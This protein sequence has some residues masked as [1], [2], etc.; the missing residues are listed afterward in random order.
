MNTRE[1]QLRPARPGRHGDRRVRVAGLPVVLV[2]MLVSCGG[3]GP[4]ASAPPSGP[5]LIPPPSLTN[6]SASA[7]PSPRPVSTATPTSS[8]TVARPDVTVATV[9]SGDRAQVGDLIGIGDGWVLAGSLDGA[10]ALWTSTDG[11]IWVREEISGLEERLGHLSA[12]A[13]RNDTMVAV[14]ESTQQLSGGILHRPLA[15]VGRPGEWRVTENFPRPPAVSAQLINVAWSEAG[16]VAGGLV[17]EGNPS[18]WVS[19]DAGATWEGPAALPADHP[20][21][22]VSELVYAI[23][24]FVAVG[25]AIGVT[26]GPGVWRSPNGIEWEAQEVPSG[27]SM[28]GAVDTDRGPLAVG[29]DGEN[30]TVWLL[31]A[32]AERLDAPD[33]RALN[34]VVVVDQHPVVAT[35]SPGSHVWIQTADGWTAVEL[36]VDN[37]FNIRS[38]AAQG[39]MVMAAGDDGTSIRT[40]ASDLGDLTR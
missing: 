26:T 2:V 17:A 31:A 5:S 12:L 10:P 7:A 18:T 37:R 19:V 34:S 8:P 30:A 29:H 3:V 13:S 14:G 4:G 35:T 15:V 16:L 25:E 40:Y 6:H 36:E 27:G 21:S 24:E 38:L 39:T 32:P 22:S 11:I 23:N 33:T 1:R 9:A 28:A 20:A